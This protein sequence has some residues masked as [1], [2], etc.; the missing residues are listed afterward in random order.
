MTTGAK[1]G[2]L[3]VFASASTA[4]VFN[5]C[6]NARGPVFRALGPHGIRS[7]TAAT[8]KGLMR[9]HRAHIGGKAAA[10]AAF[11]LRTLKCF[12]AIT[13]PQRASFCEV[14]LNSRWQQS[15]A[16]K[17][18][19]PKAP[20]R[21]RLVDEGGPGCL[22][23]HGCPDDGRVAQGQGRRAARTTR[24]RARNTAASSSSVCCATTASPAR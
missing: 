20:A 5:G 23:G 19:N 17:D 4:M 8:R 22:A 10:I 24:T 7:A 18:G 2:A 13:M 15:C 11:P 21:R 6:S 12:S 1:C 14:S 16:P 9:L 3:G